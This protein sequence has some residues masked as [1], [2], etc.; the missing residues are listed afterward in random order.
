LR[1]LEVGA[2]TGATATY[3]LPLL[4]PEVTRY[5]FTDISS[6]FTRQAKE[7]YADYP[8]VDYGLLNIE[9]PPGEQGFTAHSFDLVIAA[10][11]LHGARDLDEALRHVQ[12]LLAPGGLFL[13]EESTSWNRVYNVSNSLL[14]GLSRHEDRWRS[15]VPFISAETWG[16]ALRSNGFRRFQALPE[17]G[18]VVC[19]VMLSEGAIAAG[20]A[21]AAVDEGELRGFLA[22]R[23]PE[24][25]LPAAFVV[26]DKLPLSAN[27]KVDR[28]A[29]PPPGGAGLGARKELIPPSTPEEKVLATIWAQ[30]LG[31]E[32]VGVED[33]FFE[34]G[35]DSLLAIQLIS[36]VRDALRVELP[37][38]E[39][40]NAMT[41]AAM[42]RLVVAKETTPGLTRK[43]ARIL[44]T[45]QEMGAEDARAERPEVVA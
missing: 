12:W 17:T 5:A 16:A 35:G 33:S 34:I 31:V 27:G 9:Q 36:R 6:Y 10:D 24:Y 4:N 11:M 7:K 2:G 39:L 43:L 3:L 29:L 42:A 40:F 28:G 19:H 25:M 13:L 15:D 14:E 37:M 26:L 23:L 38:R 1:I 21:M 8:F 45:V 22:G 32:K 20:E 44:V 41:V 18:R 30:V